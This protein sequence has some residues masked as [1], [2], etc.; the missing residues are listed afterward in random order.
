MISPEDDLAGIRTVN[1]MLLFGVVAW[2]GL[3]ICCHLLLP[4][5]NKTWC[6][7][8]TL[9]SHFITWFCHNMSVICT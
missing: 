9:L 2:D 1:V 7:Y 4:S 5:D 3:I 8:L 6:C